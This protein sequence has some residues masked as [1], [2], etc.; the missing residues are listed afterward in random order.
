[1]PR[2]QKTDVD[3]RR[4][5]KSL[6]ASAFGS[7]PKDSD[8]LWHEKPVDSRTFFR[9]FLHEPMYPLQQEYCDA[10]LGTDPYEWSTDIQEAHAFWGKGSG[11]DR[12]NAKLFAYV[13]YRLLCMRS[14]AEH[15]GLAKGSPLD[16]VNVSINAKLA[17]DVFFA[18]LKGILKATKNPKTGQNWFAE[19]GVDLEE[20]KDSKKLEIN[21][22]RGI[23]AHSLNSEKY[24]GEGLNILFAVMDEVGSFRVK[25][26]MDL[27]KALRR[28]ITS[29]FSRGHGK[30]CLLSYKYHD[31]DLM[32]ILFKQG[33]SKPHVFSSHHA[34][35]EVNLGVDRQGLAEE[36]AEDPEGAQMAFECKGEGHIGGYIRRR[37]TIPQA[38][39]GENPILGDLLS[40]DSPGSIGFKDWFRGSLGRHYVVHIDLAKGKTKERGDAASFVMAHAEQMFAHYDQRTVDELLELGIDITSNLDSDPKTPRKGV[41]IDL[42]LQITSESGS[43]VDFMEVRQLVYRLKTMYGFNILYVTFDGFQSI[44]SIQDIIRHGIDASTLS[45]DKS[46]AP[47]DTMKSK[48]YQGLIRFY[49]HPILQRELREL[50]R[51]GD[52]VDHPDFSYERQSTE[53]VLKGSKDVADGLAAVAFKIENDIHLDPDIYFG[54]LEGDSDNGSAADEVGERRFTVGI[55]GQVR[56]CPS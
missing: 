34:T 52:K 31:N 40:T 16:L 38:V 12:T 48:L 27:Y 35:W 44:D 23:T 33:K 54:A 51:R 56:A 22:P 1:M 42:A 30:L 8:E 26:G 45:V 50:E 29:R 20:G 49:P 13:I 21:F 46:M 41:K 17:K 18:N 25:K 14:P 47:Y 7:L 24:T 43:E 32:E 4:A 11:K 37:Q 6:L 55:D 53:G 39:D 5:T 3:V 2:A 9:D 19:Q 15:L 36:Y 28:T 10:V